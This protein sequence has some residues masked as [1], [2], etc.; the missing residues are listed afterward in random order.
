MAY[1]VIATPL[2]GNV[3]ERTNP[4]PGPNGQLRGRARVIGIAEHHIT[5]QQNVVY[6]AE[7]GEQVGKLFV[8][9]MSDF[10]LRFKAVGDV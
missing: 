10:A 2:V 5:S 9:S 3:Y 4:M 6:I 7:S 8:T 1:K